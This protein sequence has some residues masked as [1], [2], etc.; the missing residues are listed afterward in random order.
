MWSLL[1][2]VFLLC[3]LS[4][5][6]YIWFSKCQQSPPGFGLLNVFGL[7]FNLNLPSSQLAG[8]SQKSEV[9]FT[10][11]PLTLLLCCCYCNT[12]CHNSLHYCTRELYMTDRLVTVAIIVI[13]LYHSATTRSA[14]K[15]KKKKKACSDFFVSLK[16]KNYFK[17]SLCLH[18]F[19]CFF[20]LCVCVC[21]FCVLSLGLTL[22]GTSEWS[23]HQRRPHSGGL[24]PEHLAVTGPRRYSQVSIR[25]PSSK[26]TYDLWPIE[27]QLPQTVC[28]IEK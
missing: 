16:K 14:V 27:P 21:V 23:L 24:P 12:V 26:L 1:N 11:W 25:Q 2:F 13:L 20:F 4:S 6:V 10:P 8:Q 15:K 9:Y 19:F 3:S 5:A 22:D 28:K 17:L 7:T 18:V